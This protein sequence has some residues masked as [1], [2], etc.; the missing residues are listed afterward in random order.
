MLAVAT[1]SGTFHADD[2]FAYAVLR[3]ATRGD[4]TLTRSRDAAVLERADLLFDVGGVC[5]PDR[6]RYDHHMRDKPLRPDGIPF[7]SLGLIWQDYGRASLEA[8][9]P[10]IGPVEADA[11]W[12]MLDQGLIRDIDISDNG[13]APSTPAHVALLLESWNP[14]YTEPERGET[15]AYL[16]A[17]EVAGQILCRS[18]RQAY[19]AVQATDMVAEAARTAAD[20][21]ILTLEIKVPWEDAIFDLALTAALYIVRPAGAAWSVNAVPPERGSFA[22]RKPLPDAWAGLRDAELAALTGVADATFCHP[23]R[24]VCGAKSRAGALAL[25]RLAVETP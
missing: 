10:G 1:H 20:P 23:A 4:L 11:V 15:E 25:A 22:Q 9:C 16:E 17:V 13:A 12:R 2:V 14:F 5:D 7:S 19:A 3:A 8:F 6:R 18:C 21:R 24:F